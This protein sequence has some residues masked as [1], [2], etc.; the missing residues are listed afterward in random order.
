MSKTS[1]N[2]R[3]AQLSKQNKGNHAGEDKT[4]KTHY[5]HMQPS[6]V[7]CTPKSKKGK[8]PADKTKVR[9]IPAAVAV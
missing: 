9:T 7:W 8:G 2:F 3:K 1:K 4:E 6:P 5:P